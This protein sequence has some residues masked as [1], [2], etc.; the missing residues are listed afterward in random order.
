[1]TICGF[2]FGKDLV[3]LNYPVVESV[4]S[5]LSICD[6]FVFVVGRSDDGTRELVASVD[7]K[8]Q[9]IDSD[10]PDVKIDG[11]VLSIEANKAMSL[12]ETTNCDWGLYIQADEVIHEDDREKIYATCEHWRDHD[13]VKSLLFRYLHFVLD[14]QTTDPW[15]YHKASR[16]V[17]L[18][19]SCS[20]IGDACG[21]AIRN[22]VGD[23]GNRDGYLDK[24][25]LGTHVQWA[26]WPMTGVFGSSAPA[27]IFHYGWVKT[28]EQLDEKLAMVEKLWWG[29][30]SEEEKHR[31][32][33]SKFGRFI[34]RYPILKNYRGSHPAVMADRIALH[35]TF[36][37]CRNRW[38]QPRFY[39]EVIRHGFHG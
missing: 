24:N 1:M 20:I 31:R 8:I 25:F 28:N 6:R 13:Q 35:P 2:S 32:M 5:A 18:D 34:E 39:S 21:P 14:Y 9:I 30:L 37:P 16:I 22:Y 19:G 12:A 3:R 27:R 7:P 4:R 10:W 26:D 29:T 36:K 23:V 17:R 38:L 33:Q 11:T 15:M